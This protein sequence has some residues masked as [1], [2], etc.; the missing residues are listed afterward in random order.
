LSTTCGRF[1]F[2]F[3]HAI[4]FLTSFSCNNICIQLL[5]K[6][7]LCPRVVVSIR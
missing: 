3:V 6:C 5:T 7:I 1:I 4:L 2:I